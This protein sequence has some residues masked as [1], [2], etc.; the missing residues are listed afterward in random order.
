[1]HCTYFITTDKRNARTSKK[2]REQAVRWIRS[3]DTGHEYIEHPSMPGLTDWF[4]VGGR[5]SG[6]LQMKHDR[7]WKEIYRSKEI[8]FT[9]ID[10]KRHLLDSEVKAKKHIIQKIWRNI[11]GEGICPLLR[12]HTRHEGYEDD[13]VVITHEHYRD[14]LLYFLRKTQGKMPYFSDGFTQHGNWVDIDGDP[15]SKRFIGHKWLVLV[16]CHS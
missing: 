10:G 11:G 9:I 6:R 4:V 14:L 16:D 15:I 13:A 1:M 5:W 12:T 2:A 8:E 7:F 3:K